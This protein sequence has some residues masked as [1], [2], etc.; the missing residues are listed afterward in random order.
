[1]DLKR[2]LSELPTLSLGRRF[3]LGPD[4]GE[5]SNAA[6]YRSAERVR[7]RFITNYCCCKFTRPDKGELAAFYDIAQHKA[8]VFDDYPKIVSFFEIELLLV[9]STYRKQTRKLPK[10]AL[11][12]P[13][14]LIWAATD[15]AVL[16]SFP[17]LSH[18]PIRKVNVP[19]EHTIYFANDNDRFG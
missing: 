3:S 1:M 11:Y 17:W 12:H 14:S 15:H 16:S 13:L 2:A 7:S 4:L 19:R 5:D 10:R 18:H 6:L 8:T 9:P